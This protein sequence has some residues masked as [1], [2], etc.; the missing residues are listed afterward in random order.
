MLTGRWYRFGYACV[1]FGT[2]I[3]MR[4]YCRRTGAG[5]GTPDRE[6]RFRRVEAMAHELMEAVGRVI[7][8]LPVSLVA[9]VLLRRGESGTG[10]LELKAEVHRLM[11][12]LRE[13]G[14]HIYLPRA[15]QD[16]SVSVGLRML[17]LR[18]LVE[19]RDEPGHE[20][21]VRELDE[22]VRIA[23]RA[24]PVVFELRL[25]VLQLRQEL[26]VLALEPFRLVRFLD[27]RGLFRHTS[28][29]A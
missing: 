5:F 19:D 29:L 15:D 10:E 25:Q 14:A 3:S 8:V 18:H 16:Y 23:L 11:Q 2:P 27:R 26:L 7:P 17:I 6:E 20:A 9:T 1:N 4:E 12:A 13:A 28:H 22:R 24:L 21:L